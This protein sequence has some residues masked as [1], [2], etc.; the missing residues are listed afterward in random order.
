MPIKTPHPIYSSDEYPRDGC[1]ITVDVLAAGYRISIFA[2]GS[3]VASRN[4]I[5]VFSAKTSER[6]S[7]I[8]ECLATG[9]KVP[10][11]VSQSGASQT[12]FEAI[13]LQRTAEDRLVTAGRSALVVGSEETEQKF[14]VT[15]HDQSAAAIKGPILWMVFN[16]KRGWH[17]RAERWSGEALRVLI[18][19]G[20]DPILEREPSGQQFLNLRPARSPE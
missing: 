11:E 16:P 12:D 2:P 4:P 7:Q 18:P 19:S 20:F 1:V 17:V 5:E 15:S 8:V 6:L 14:C 10:A 9:A 13:T 3:D